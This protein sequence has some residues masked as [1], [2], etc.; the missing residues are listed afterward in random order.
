MTILLKL[1]LIYL[2]L[3]FRKCVEMKYSLFFII[4]FVNLIIT[5]L[6]LTKLLF[7]K[8]NISS[9]YIPKILND[10]KR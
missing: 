10:I 2:R 7:A 5:V 4:I 3:N 1:S 9:V 8:I 6:V